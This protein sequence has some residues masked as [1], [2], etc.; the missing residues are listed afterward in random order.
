METHTNDRKN[1][2]NAT[3]SKKKTIKTSDGFTLMMIDDVM[4]DAIE[5]SL[6]VEVVFLPK[7]QKPEKAKQIYDHFEIIFL[8]HIV[9]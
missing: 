1:K 7:T 3:R 4:M 2:K 9:S 6:L 5:K 8:V